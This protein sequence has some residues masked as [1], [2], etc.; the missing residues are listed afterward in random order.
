MVWGIL[1]R[2]GDCPQEMHLDL[3]PESDQ[4][5]LLIL[6]DSTPEHE[7]WIEDKLVAL[8]K[9]AEEER[10]E[11]QAA[12]DCWR[13][14]L[15]IKATVTAENQPGLAKTDEASPAAGNEVPP[16]DVE[17]AAPE[18]VSAVEPGAD[19]Q[20]AAQEEPG[21]KATEKKRG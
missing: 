17:E 7:A 4:A 12:E 8:S 5:L 14:W 9:K 15:R 6:D 10:A 2:T 16:V 11:T 3:Y 13:R 20:P 19:D 1:Y 21:E 18:I